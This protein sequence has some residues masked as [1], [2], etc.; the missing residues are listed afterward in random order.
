MNLSH[1][2]NTTHNVNAMHNI[3]TTS[4]QRK[5]VAVN[6]SQGLSLGAPSKVPAS[7]L[8]EDFGEQSADGNGED[9]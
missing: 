6:H 7:L 1:N 9:S 8:V 2:A 3:T 4:V 5:T